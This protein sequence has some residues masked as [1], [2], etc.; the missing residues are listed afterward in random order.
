MTTTTTTESIPLPTINPSS[1]PSTSTSMSTSPHQ[2]FSVDFSWRKFKSLITT[3]PSS[4]S[5]KPQPLYIVSYR[6]VKPNLVFKSALD[7]SVFGTG[8]IPP[9]IIDSDCELRGRKIKVK[10]M[11]RFKTEYSHMSHTFNSSSDANAAEK[12]PVQMTWISTSGWKNWD[13][14]CLDAAQMPVAKFSANTMSLKNVGTF[15][16]LGEEA[17]GNERFKEEVVVVGTTLLYTMVL[18][19]TSFLSL[20]GAVFA[21]PGKK[22]EAKD[23]D[24][25]RMDGKDGKVHAE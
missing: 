14:I 9:I 25:E 13:F 24:G 10:A 23:G 3:R 17:I 4:P 2:A 15:E 11:K 8:F 12:D 19:T 20:F 22:I 6:P 18:R 5:E 1:Y 16:F 7:N 21:R